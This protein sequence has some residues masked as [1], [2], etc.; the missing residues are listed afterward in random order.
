MQATSITEN[1]KKYF[2][3]GVGLASHTGAIV[4]KTMNDFV[5]EGRVSEA[6]G[7]K[8]VDNAIKKIEAKMP[9]FQAKYHKALNKAAKFVDT[10]MG[11]LK[12]AITDLEKKG[13]TKTSTT[14]KKV[15]MSIKK[16]A[17]KVAHKAPVK[18]VTKAVKKVVA[19]PKK[20]VNKVVAASL[21]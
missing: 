9:E 13:G 17:T 3:S 14:K 15:E 21:K 16:V 1:L 11:M 7:K 12:K 8:I 6:D 5:K 2:Y 19:N 18:T 10:E 20:A 4:Q